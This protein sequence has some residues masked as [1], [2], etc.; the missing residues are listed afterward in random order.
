MIKIK[1]QIYQAAG[2]LL[3]VVYAQLFFRYL[4]LRSKKLAFANPKS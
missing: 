3:I 4:S 1:S 2:V